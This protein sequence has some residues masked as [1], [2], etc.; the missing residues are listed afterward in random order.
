MDWPHSSSS[1]S[2]RKLKLN[3]T[4]GCGITSDRPDFSSS[5][6]EVLDANLPPR[7]QNTR[8][9]HSL[10]G[11]VIACVTCQSIERDEK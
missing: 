1:S 10:V 8:V 2:I 3:N 9:S 6:D 5:K 11:P 7:H 4:R